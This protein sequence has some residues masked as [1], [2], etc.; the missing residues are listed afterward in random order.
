MVIRI[1]CIS[2]LLLGMFENFHNKKFWFFKNVSSR[3]KCARFCWSLCR[4]TDRNCYSVF[5]TD[6]KNTVIVPGATTEQLF[7]SVLRNVAF[8]SKEREDEGEEERCYYGV[9]TFSVY[10]TVPDAEVGF[11]SNADGQGPVHLLLP[12]PEGAVLGLGSA[13]TECLAADLCG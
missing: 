13:W 3:G 11:K 8:L 4:K 2:S 12:S 10:R 5:P 7:S 6:W 9:F 1:R